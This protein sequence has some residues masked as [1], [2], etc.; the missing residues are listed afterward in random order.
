MNDHL[1]MVL[2]GGAALTSHGGRGMTWTT[3]LSRGLQGDRRRLYA[4]E[5]RAGKDARDA[6]ADE[7]RAG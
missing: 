5:S 2:L 7:Q 6:Q 3:R 1:S 4:A